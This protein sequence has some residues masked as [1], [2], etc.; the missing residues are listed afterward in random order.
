MYHDVFISYS[1]QD[2]D[3]VLAFCADIGH[4]V[5]YFL[6]EK[7]LRWGIS[8]GRSV[9]DALSGATSVLPILSPASLK[10]GWVPFEIGYARGRGRQVLPL[11]THPGLDVPSYLGDIKCLLNKD[12]AINYFRSPDWKARSGA[13]RLLQSCR[14]HTITEAAGEVGLVDVEDRQNDQNP[15]PPPEFYALAKKEIA[16]SGV[17]AFRT[18][19][20]HFQILQ[21][22]LDSGKRLYVLIVAPDSPALPG[23][24]HAHLEI[25]IPRQIGEVINRIIRTKLVNYPNF[26]IRFLQDVPPF[27]G[28]MIDG[29]LSP[30]STI[31]D[32]AEG[33]IR[34]QPTTKYQTRHSGM[35]FQFARIP[36]GGGF[37]LFAADFRDQWANDGSNRP[38]LVL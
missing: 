6:D 5:S 3:F 20:Q 18:F 34:V 21:R 15:L 13:A 14:G 32:D 11:L 36:G 23:L 7:E 9:T 17:S 12:E 4:Y 38:D 25:D 26:Q 1:H 16:I 35:I 37:D 8:I 29:D 27:T 10:S 24:I 31:P 22:A 2:R 28:N 19:D 30:S 33:H